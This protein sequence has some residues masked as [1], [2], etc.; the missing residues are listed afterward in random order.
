MS[1]LITS[2]SGV[3][4]RTAPERG[5]KQWAIDR[6]DDRG[7]DRESLHFYHG[8]PSILDMSGGL[9]SG[10][11][12]GISSAR[13]VEL[14]EQ[15]GSAS[16]EFKSRFTIGFEFEKNSF[17]RGAMKTH[18]LFCGF[19]RD[20]SCGV[21]AV[22]NVMPLVYSGK[23]RDK[24]HQFCFENRHI[25]DD[26]FSPSN[27]GGCGGHIS[28]GFQMNGS[29]FS[30]ETIANNVRKYAGILY[31][32]YQKRLKSEFVGAHDLRMTDGLNG[33]KF[34]PLRVKSGYVEFRIPSRVR[35]VA[36]V[37]HRYDLMMELMHTAMIRQD[38]YRRFLSRVRPIVERMY[39]R[40]EQKVEKVMSDAI[41]FQAYIMTGDA[42]PEIEQAIISAYINSRGWR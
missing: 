9:L 1:N 38:S 23:L 25:I 26:Q 41:H 19:E 2:A 27:R 8:K 24:M 28:L 12:R 39:G 33:H 15:R 30:G 22:T 6:Y 31:A 21:E 14:F 16:H 34:R 17:Y 3:V 11:L 10:D 18:P 36:Q 20:S 5:R 13:Q 32:L 4:Y 35:S 29:S 7:R 37:M 40:D 42:A